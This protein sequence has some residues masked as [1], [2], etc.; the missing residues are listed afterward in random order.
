MPQARK[1]KTTPAPKSTAGAKKTETKEGSNPST[2]KATRQQVDKNTVYEDAGTY[3]PKA[4]ANVA[5]YAAVKAVLPANYATVV[6][7]IPEH[8]DFFGYLVRR[9][10]LKPQE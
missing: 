9:G 10:A 7:A 2:G 1:P 8:T 6:A 3:N 5:S 4:E